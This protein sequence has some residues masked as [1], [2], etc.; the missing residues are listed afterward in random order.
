MSTLRTWH[1]NANLDKIQASYRENPKFKKNQAVNKLNEERS[2]LW[3]RL[4][5]W[6]FYLLQS[7]VKLFAIF[8]DFLFFVLKLFFNLLQLTFQFFLEE[9]KT[10]SIKTV[11]T[12]KWYV[13]YCK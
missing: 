2:F 1:W 13:Y 9:N 12:F 10:S 3:D 5:S 8:V 11:G 6:A 4:Q 7:F